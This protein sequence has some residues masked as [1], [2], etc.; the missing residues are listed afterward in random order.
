MDAGEVRLSR[1]MEDR[2]HAIGRAPGRSRATVSVEYGG[3]PAHLELDF[4]L[5]E[6]NAERPILQV[7]RT[8]TFAFPGIVEPRELVSVRARHLPVGEVKMIVRFESVTKQE[9]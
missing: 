7:D 1:G 4:A 3:R 6:P 9:G 2:F 8:G 5:G